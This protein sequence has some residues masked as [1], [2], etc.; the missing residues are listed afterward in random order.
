[1]KDDPTLI[2]VVFRKENGHISKASNSALE[3]VSGEFT[4]FMDHDDLLAPDALYH[5]VK[6]IN[7]KP[8]FGHPVHRRGQ[9]G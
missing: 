5:V 7:M 4:A 8:R 6:R 9:G 3:L 2:Q 1:M